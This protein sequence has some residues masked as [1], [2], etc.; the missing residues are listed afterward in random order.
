MKRYAL[1]FTVFCLFVGIFI[2]VGIRVA[3][4]YAASELMAELDQEAKHACNCSIHYDS[5]EVSLFRMRAFGKNVRLVENNVERLHFNK[6]YAYFSLKKIREHTVLLSELQLNTGYSDGAGPESAT[7]KFIDWLAA[8]IPP[9]KDRP[10]RWRIKLQNLKMSKAH[11][12]EKLSDGIIKGD[13]VSLL[14]NRRPDTDFD[15]KP[16]IGKLII[17]RSDKSESKIIEIGKLSS[18]FT[19]HD[20]SVDFE[21]IKL[22]HGDSF[23]TTT[24]A[25]D[26]DHQNGI[27]GKLVY[28]IDSKSIKL[29]DWISFV[30]SGQG[31][32]GGSLT[33][34]TLNASLYCPTQSPFIIKPGELSPIGFNQVAGNFEVSSI[35][36][37]TQLKMT[38]LDAAGTGITFNTKAP[39]IL[40]SKQ[41]SGEIDLQID[42]LSS[43][44][45]SLEKIRSNIKF[46]GS[47]AEPV[48]TFNLASDRAVLGGLPLEPINVAG[49]FNGKILNLDINHQPA[50][51]G[52]LAAKI[53]L[54]LGADSAND[55]NQRAIENFEVT[56]REFHPIPNSQALIVNGTAHA[57]GGLDLKTIRA[58]ADFSISNDSP[59]TP[60]VLS[61]KGTITDGAIDLSAKSPSE[62]LLASFRSNLNDTK[63]G[64]AL[65]KLSNL[66]LSEINPGIS[67]GQVDA[68]LDYSFNPN[69]AATGSGTLKID[70]FFIGCEPYQIQ[71]GAPQ[72]LPIKSGS[73]ALPKV[74]FVGSNSNLLLNG[75]ISLVDGLNLSTQGSLQVNALLGLIPVVDDIQGT[76]TADLTLKGPFSAPVISGETRITKGELAVESADISASNI[77]GGIKIDNHLLQIDNVTGLLNGG[78]AKLTGA[79]NPLDLER[80]NIAAS[81]SDISLEPTE[82]TS[83]IFGGSIQLSKSDNGRPSIQ[84]IIS[85]NSAEFRRNISLPKMLREIARGLLERAQ[86]K[87]YTQLPDLDLNIEVVAPHNIFINTNWVG[88]ELQANMLVTGTLANPAIKGSMQT[89]SGWFGLKNRQFDITSGH[90]NFKPGYNEPLLDIIS[91]T[92]LRGRSGE[93]ILVILEASGTLS[94]PKITL[95]SDNGLPEKEIL[96]LLPGS[97]DV[98]TTSRINRSGTENGIG[99]IPI[100]DRTSILDFNS[101]VRELT[102]I[103]S[104]GI[105]PAFNTRLGVIEPTVIATKRL[106]DDLS[107]VGSSFFGST[108]SESSVRL[109]YDLNSS[110]NLSALAETVS[111]KSNTALGADLTYT[112]LARSEKFL[113]VIIHGRRNFKQRR[114]LDQ[115]KL[116]P[117]SRLPTAQLKAVRK[118]LISFYNSHGYF[119]ADALVSCTEGRELCRKLEIYIHEGPQGQAAALRIEGENLPQSILKGKL[120]NL[121]EK[122]PATE[123]FLKK[124]EQ[125]LLSALRAEGYIGAR[126][127][128]SYEGQDGSENYSMVL[129]ALSGKPV[130]FIF[131]G[132]RIFSPKDFLDTIRLFK[133]RQPFGNNTINIL[134]KNIE[135]KY[136]EFGYL[137]CSVTYDKSIDANSERITY[138]VRIEEGPQYKVS[139]V[140]LLGTNG[141]TPEFIRNS[142]K[143][144]SKPDFDEIFRPQFAIAEQLDGTTGVLRNV[145]IEEGYPDVSINH[146]LE[147]NEADRTVIINYEISEGK[148]R[149]ANWL[150]VRG[151][152]IELAMPMPPK[153]PYSIPKAN[154][155]LDELISTL[156]DAGY[157]NASVSSDFDFDSRRLII[158]IEPG[159]QTQIDEI[160]TDG[161]LNISN[162]VIA[163]KLGLKN[164]D[165]WDAQKINDARRKLLRLGLFSRVDIVPADGKLDGEHEKMTVNVN[166]RPLTTLQVGT[167]L[168]SEYGL[169]LFGEAADK[170]LFR[171]GKTL[172]LRS[173]IYLDQSN[174][175]LNSGISQGIANLRYSDPNFLNASNVLTEDLSFQKLQTSTFEFDLDQV[176]L[177][178]YIYRTSDNGLSNSLGHT[179]LQQNLTDVSPDAIL[180]PLDEGNVTLSFLNGNVE[181]DQRDYPLNPT[182]GYNLNFDYKLASR[183]IMSDADFY[184]I[185]GRFSYL[186]PLP[187]L[188]DR[189][190]FAVASHLASA[191]TYGP[192]EEI[193]ISQRFYLGGRNTVRGYGENLLGPRGSEGSVLGGDVLFANNCELR[194]LVADNTS[195]HT[196]FDAGNIYLRNFDSGVDLGNL[197]YGTGV[198]VRYLSPIGPIGFDVAHPIPERSGERTLRLYF[199]IG[200]LF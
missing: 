47:M 54:A 127:T 176:S 55:P 74:G 6:V 174:A 139:A 119:K 95:S 70:N 22:D 79:I 116:S 101:F 102:R 113:E 178:S 23:I 173:D 69:S 149:K 152:P 56:A 146:S 104:I 183:A 108:A 81:F 71:I 140:H 196:F 160:E 33:S 99:E 122:R 130:S 17:D 192:T 96:A 180:S 117:S 197:R 187:I 91:E 61:G 88:A 114:I 21:K 195:L 18:F 124:R 5:V 158:R 29:P 112:V 27:S 138:Q 65:V 147:R 51:G 9:E 64:E 53:A 141:L 190:G 1:R 98:L 193:P 83:M 136:R 142:I 105:E 100:F 185:G 169:H 78:N 10:G 145:Y 4:H 166:E 87:K 49:N 7:Y 97:Q 194:Y 90:I 25:I 28:L 191:W 40:T 38:K 199:S 186:H 179:I 167:G 133:R 126:V 170:S 62:H 36:N 164:G 157:I 52:S 26:L 76:A 85:I 115:L 94:N 123:A 131:E 172:A 11:F 121:E 144:S 154:R 42:S 68:A 82:D 12:T 50:A 175:D 111:T 66:Q 80:S 128:G 171:D 8:P 43:P 2:G 198:G 44:S 162:E 151:Y 163:K 159:N 84:G 132:N 16:T 93:P 161:N 165:T 89:L 103:D 14:V 37:S 120:I 31:A 182:R 20:H 48:L 150:D 153:S 134:A 24:A 106:T 188:G 32:L 168:N 58:D 57:H 143:Q 77:N 30:L 60:I 15:L 67:C 75:T 148:E 34:P 45:A 177:A 156:N 107:L 129:K 200:T 137:D 181:Y 46:S 35:D 189:F 135:R 3:E 63:T 59:T 72:N 92:S 19:I 41:L 86:R 184:S 155:Y 125:Y 73:L 39:I 118:N 109:T 110:L 13:D